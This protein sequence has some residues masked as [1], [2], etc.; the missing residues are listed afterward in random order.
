MKTIK[1]VEAEVEVVK[2]AALDNIKAILKVEIKEAIKVVQ[3]KHPSITEV[4]FHNNHPW[5]VY[6]STKEA[7]WVLSRNEYARKNYI[8]VVYKPHKKGVNN[9][10]PVKQIRY[11]SSLHHL[12]RLL[13]LFAEVEHQTIRYT[14]KD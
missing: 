1:Q 9:D 5:I 2:K 10:S 3:K 11:S 8:A 4:I 13:D 12:Y 6:H 7:E 14:I